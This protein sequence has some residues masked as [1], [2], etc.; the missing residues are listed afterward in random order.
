MNNELD[1]PS[2]CGVENSASDQGPGCPIPHPQE[3]PPLLQVPAQQYRA[4]RADF[5]SHA[6]LPDDSCKR[7]GSCPVTMLITGN[8][9]TFGQSMHLLLISLTSCLISWEF[10]AFPVAE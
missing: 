1:K 6:D 5:I 9:K 7:T 2:K 3:L 10:N 8:N 4:V